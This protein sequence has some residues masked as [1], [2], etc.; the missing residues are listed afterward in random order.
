MESSIITVDRDGEY[1]PCCYLICRVTGEP[2]NY[3]WDTRDESNT[4]LIQT[5]WDYPGIASTFGFVPCESC[6]GQADGTVDCI[7]KT[8][9][10]MI[11]EAARF[12]D[13][14]CETADNR[15]FVDDPGY[16]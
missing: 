8:A 5:D 2:G 7:H 4:V 13:D 15:R 10:Y 9:A 12:L 11:Q 3:D 16:F 6:G 1:A 14:L